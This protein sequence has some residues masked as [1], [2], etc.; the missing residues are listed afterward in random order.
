MGEFKAMKEFIDDAIV[1]MISAA[2]NE[3][4]DEW[5]DEKI[6]QHCESLVPEELRR[7]VMDWSIERGGGGWSCSN[8]LICNGTLLIFVFSSRDDGSALLIF[9]EDGEEFKK[10]GIKSVEFYSA[11]GS[12]WF[13]KNEIMELNSF[14]Q[15][16]KGF[17]L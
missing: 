13:I 4:K 7:D 2:A 17:A 12:L 5:D 10:R 3:D 15:S 9:G 6:I 1:K 14:Y 8:M 16:K 11:E